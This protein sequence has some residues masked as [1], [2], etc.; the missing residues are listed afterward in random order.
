MIRKR[1]VKSSASP[2][3]LIYLTFR[4]ASIRTCLSHLIVMSDKKINLA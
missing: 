3:D 2:A 4:G 1:E